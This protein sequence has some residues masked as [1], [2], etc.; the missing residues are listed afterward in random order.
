MDQTF[1][2]HCCCPYGSVC[3]KPAR[4]AL[5]QLKYSAVYLKASVGQHELPSVPAIYLTLSLDCCWPPN[6]GIPPGRT[7]DLLSVPS[8]AMPTAPDL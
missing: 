6:P 7:W 3:G 5:T 2:T 8:E 4:L 1:L